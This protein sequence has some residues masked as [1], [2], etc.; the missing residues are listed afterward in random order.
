MSTTH[1]TKV[2]RATP[3]KVYRAFTSPEALETWLAPGDMTGKVHRFALQEGGGYEMSL[4]YPET[5]KEQ[6]GKTGAKEDRY[7]ARFE[8][9]E[10]GKRIVEVIRFDTPDAQLQGEMTLEVRFE[11]VGE[12]STSVTMVFEN[13]PEG[14]RPEDN[15][16]GTELSL[17]KLEKY[18]LEKG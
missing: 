1:N 17:Q 7:S 2:I 9:L 11:P 13:V 10:P 16:K 12:E 15:E 5:E 3:E 14:I 4:F 18:L 8:V 6:R